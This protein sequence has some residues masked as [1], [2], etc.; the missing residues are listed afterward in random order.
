[1]LFARGPFYFCLT[2]TGMKRM[3]R[4]SHTH[5]EVSIADTTKKKRRRG[6]RQ[7][8]ATNYEK[9]MKTPFAA[10][11]LNA[12]RRLFQETKQTNAVTHVA[13]AWV[14]RNTSEMLVGWGGEQAGNRCFGS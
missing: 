2:K 6:G 10:V 13:T 4:P 14:Q 12:D 7:D 8:K 5:S 3:H 11:L 1:M 9:G